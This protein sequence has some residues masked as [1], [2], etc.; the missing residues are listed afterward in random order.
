[1][2]SEG[3]PTNENSISKENYDD[4][5]FDRPW[6]T[7]DFDFG[8]PLGKGK[9]GSVYLAREKRSVHKAIVAI[10]I[11][12][13]SQLQKAGVE[14]QFRREL[15]IQSH[16][17]H[18]NILRMYG[19][20]HDDSRIYI[21]LEFA[22]YGELYKRLKKVGRFD[23]RTAATYMYQISDAL[24]YLHSK[25][26]IH[27][28]IKPE[29]LLLG[30]FGEL[31][32]ADFGWSVHAPSLRRQT[33]CGTLDYLPP[34]MVENKRHD[35]KVDHWCI[36]VLCY[37]LLVGRPPFESQSSQD[38]Y[39]K[40]VSCYIKFPEYVSPGARDLIYRLLQK[41]PSERLAL[42]DVRKHYWIVEHAEKNEEYMRYW[43]EVN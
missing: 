18:P 6:N 22:C 32:I 1:M 35:E 25:Q 10:K 5:K 3:L 14:H 40:I 39:K 33:L 19:W 43:K 4:E 8:R 7:K 21:I 28:D 36:G 37:E 9:F 13:K 42:K 26:V 2:E 15:E 11:L 20:F 16:L 29:N 31:K 24:M 38:T 34:E 27:R 30:A 17:K 41:N 23:E 12:F